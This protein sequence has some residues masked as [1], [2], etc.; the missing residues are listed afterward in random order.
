MVR[1]QLFFILPH[2]FLILESYDNIFTF[3]LV[4]TV[5]VTIISDAE[6]LTTCFFLEILHDKNDKGASL[7]P[8]WIFQKINDATTG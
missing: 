7:L 1:D 4:E 5:E 6:F 8:S 3:W 2:H